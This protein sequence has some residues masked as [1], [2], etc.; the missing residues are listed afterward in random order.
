MLE[1]L[2]RLIREGGS[3]D[4]GALAKRL[5][6]SPAMVLEMMD[7]L[8]RSGLIRTYDPGQSSCEHCSLIQMCDPD[9][10]KRDTDHMWLYEEK[11]EA[12]PERST[13]K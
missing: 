11:P 8:R 12:I 6:T 13:A 4:T 9:K 10:K 7:H 3:F 2:L 5:N 1:E